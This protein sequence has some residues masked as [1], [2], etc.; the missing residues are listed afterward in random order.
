MRKM[1]TRDRC[2]CGNR[3][4][5]KTGEWSV[6]EDDYRFYEFVEIIQCKLCG[7]QYV[8]TDYGMKKYQ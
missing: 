8:Y 3:I 7:K 4:F 2:D 6:I 5:V 1:E